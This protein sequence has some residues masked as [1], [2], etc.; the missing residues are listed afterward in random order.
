LAET[1]EL[2]AEREKGQLNL[3]E[4]AS[5]AGDASRSAADAD[6][7]NGVGA[8][9][10][11]DDAFLEGAALSRAAAAAAADETPSV[12]ACVRLVQAADSKKTNTQIYRVA[13][14]GEIIV[15]KDKTEILRTLKASRLVSLTQLTDAAEKNLLEGMRVVRGGSSS[16]NRTC[17]Y[18]DANYEY[19]TSAEK[20]VKIR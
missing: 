1:S 18:V 2:P 7:Q 8:V 16:N 4:H 10:S 13:L 17:Y 14:T 11:G 19:H 3:P 5:A 12:M 20:L 6:D 9:V 15:G